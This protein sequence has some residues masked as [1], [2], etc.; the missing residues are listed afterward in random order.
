MLKRA[1]VRNL[2]SGYFYDASI[3]V[4]DYESELRLES[5]AMSEVSTPRSGNMTGRHSR[6][7]SE[8]PLGGWKSDR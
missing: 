5:A 4:P 2:F 3:L 1:D 6:A 7:I 8:I